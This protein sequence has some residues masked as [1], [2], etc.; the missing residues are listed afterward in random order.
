M[1]KALALAIVGMFALVYLAM[2]AQAAPSAKPGALHAEIDIVWTDPPAA[3]WGSMTGDINGMSIY[4][5]N[6]DHPN[7]VSGHAETHILIHFHELFTICVGEVAKP[8]GCQQPT[9]YIT[10]YEEG[11][12]VL[13][14]PAMEYHFQAH[15]WV[16]GASADYAYMIGWK[17]LENGAVIADPLN[18]NVGHGFAKVLIA[19]AD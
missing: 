2:P 5:P 1:K 11:V 9:S 6:P 3:W 17:Y 18:P 16:T 4:P 7:W 15:G 8:D 13:N 14:P 19:P 10:G 12:Y